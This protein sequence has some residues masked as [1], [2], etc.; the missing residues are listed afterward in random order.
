MRCSVMM[1][2][3]HQLRHGRQDAMLSEMLVPAHSLTCLDVMVMCQLVKTRSCQTQVLCNS[4]VHMPMNVVKQV[5]DISAERPRIDGGQNS[6]DLP[7]LVQN[8]LRLIL[9]D[10]LA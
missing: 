4:Q 9:S 1:M 8:R 6:P 5:P 3:L 7:R 10:N 2:M